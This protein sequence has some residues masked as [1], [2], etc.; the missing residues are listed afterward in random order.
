MLDFI[1][2]IITPMWLKRFL[3]KDEWVTEPEP[4]NTTELIDSDDNVVI[5]NEPLWDSNDHII[6]HMLWDG[7]DET[8]NMGLEEFIE[9]LNQNAE[10]SMKQKDQMKNYV[11]DELEQK[12]EKLPVTEP[13][14]I[15]KKRKKR[16]KLHYNMRKY[17]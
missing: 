7:L 11:I 16:R 9:D 6:D 5:T 10:M 13:P 17:G 1:K 4:V 15:V 8:I 14:K 12:S 2:W 3:S